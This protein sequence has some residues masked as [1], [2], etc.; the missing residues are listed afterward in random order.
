MASL[1]TR[2]PHVATAKVVKNRGQDV[3]KALYSSFRA[4]N[5][6][7]FRGELGAPLVLITNAHSARTLGD[8]V[9]RDIHGLDSRIRIAPTAV[10]RGDLFSADVLLHEMVHAWQHEIDRDLEMGYRG[11]GPKFARECNRIG[12][13]L[14]LPEVG[15]KGRGGLPDCAQWPMVV[16]PEGYYPEG[17]WGKKPSEPR[18]PSEPADHAPPAQEKGPGVCLFHAAITWTRVLDKAASGSAEAREECR[19]AGE[20]LQL[21]ARAYAR[22]NGHHFEECAV[23]NAEIGE[24]TKTTARLPEKTCSCEREAILCWECTQRA[25]EERLARLVAS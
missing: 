1:D 8:Y 4:F 9:P 16:R 21:A 19:T 11:H 20:L 2:S 15:V 25:G 17:A 7:F 3:A 12:A 10:A 22:R 6:R 24:V 18:K 5:R 13:L 14:G 23:C